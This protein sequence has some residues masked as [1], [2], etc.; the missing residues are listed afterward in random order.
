[1][2]R[3]RQRRKK[4]KLLEVYWQIISRKDCKPYGW[5]SVL[6]KI[7]VFKWTFSFRLSIYKFI[8]IICL[9]INFKVLTT[10][11]WKISKKPWPFPAKRNSSSPHEPNFP[12]APNPLSRKPNPNS[13][14]RNS[15]A[16]SRKKCRLTFPAWQLKYQL[17]LPSQHK[18]P[19]SLL[20]IWG[21]GS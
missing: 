6:A 16:V 21:T 1:M 8:I 14:S 4:R 10:P 9:I 12:L 13:I 5:L 18:N 3:C 2:W 11:R 15:K 20:A 17:T 19:S 7:K